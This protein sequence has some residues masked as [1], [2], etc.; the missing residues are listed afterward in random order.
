MAAVLPAEP[1]PASSQSGR[2]G[3]ALREF[4]RTWILGGLIPVYLAV[5]FLGTLAR[6]NGESMAP[7]LHTGQVLLLLKY[8]RWL[9]AWHLG[10]TGRSYLRYG[11]VVVFKAPADSPYAYETVYGLRHRPYNIKRVVGLPGDT[12]EIRE[13]ELIRNGKRVAETY[14][15]PDGYMNAA[16]PQVVPPGKV[17]VLGDNRHLGDSLDSRAYGPVDL[18]DVAGTANLRLWPQPGSLRPR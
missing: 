11:D 13:G 3:G 2:S 10:R 17:W 8:P 4:W 6:V 18:R 12:V 16:A 1:S 7:T 15:T 14:T 9:H 5:T